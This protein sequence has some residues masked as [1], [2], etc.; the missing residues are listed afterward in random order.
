MNSVEGLDPSRR[1]SHQNEQ[2][3][4]ASPAMLGDTRCPAHS[5]S[6][7]AAMMRERMVVRDAR[8]ELDRARAQGPTYN[9]P[10]GSPSS[11]ASGNWRGQAQAGSESSAAGGSQRSAA[12]DEVHRML[13]RGD[14]TTGEGLIR[15]TER[16]VREFA[17][18][19][20]EPRRFEILMRAVRLM[21]AL[22][23]Q[24]PAPPIDEPA[25]QSAP[26]PDEPLVVE[27]DRRPA[28]ERAEEL[29][30]ERPRPLSGRYAIR[31][32]T[33]SGKP[34]PAIR[35]PTP[36]IAGDYK[37]KSR[38]EPSRRRGFLASSRR[39]SRRPR[40]KSARRLRFAP[41]HRSG[42]RDVD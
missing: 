23:D 22:R 1:C 26:S 15:L 35:P 4:C 32:G 20:L 21:A 24:F 5:D 19:K 28:A 10:I 25:E 11:R 37:A 8:A 31:T 3:R 42:N 14:I 27:A 30:Q 36:Q 13:F 9:P 38:G 33:V 7:A 39:R 16:L 34:E 12:Q 29:K 2:G 41:P 40:C 17:A 18:G 6:A